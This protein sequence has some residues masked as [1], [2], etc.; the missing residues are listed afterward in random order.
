[1]VVVV[2]VVDE[3]DVVGGTV[4]VVVS[5]TGHSSPVYSSWSSGSR[6]GCTSYSHG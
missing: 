5:G 2:V 3:V 6:Q 4:V 1:V